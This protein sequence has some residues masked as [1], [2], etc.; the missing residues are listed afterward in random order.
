MFEGAICV[1][2][3]DISGLQCLQNICCDY[4]AQHE[5]ALIFNINNSCRPI[6]PKGCCGSPA[7]ESA[8]LKG[9]PSSFRATGD[10]I[11]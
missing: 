10:V 6:F 7:R 8:R 2:A 4:A 5:I 3:T 9:D 1:F 11:I